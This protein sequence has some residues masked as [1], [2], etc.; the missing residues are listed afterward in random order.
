MRKLPRARTHDGR[1]FVVFASFVVL[2]FAS[3]DVVAPTPDCRTRCD[4]DDNIT[5][6]KNKMP[7][8]QQYK[9]KY[10][11]VTFTRARCSWSTLIGRRTCG[12]CTSLSRCLDG[13]DDDDDD[14]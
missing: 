3:F 14:Y 9:I 5:K 11:K 12:C 4:N 13:D 7:L 2:V 8:N 6:S 10:K 1:A